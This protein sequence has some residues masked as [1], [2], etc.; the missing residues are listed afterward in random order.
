[1]S[2]I[3]GLVGCVCVRATPVPKDAD[4]TCAFKSRGMEQACAA[5]SDKALHIVL[6]NITRDA[7]LL[8][9][10][11]NGNQAKPKTWQADMLQM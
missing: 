11:C 2:Y 10:I 9:C 6:I 7:W 8:T 4:C 5:P 3:A 1:M